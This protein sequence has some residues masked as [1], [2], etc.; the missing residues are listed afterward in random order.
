[1]TLQDALAILAYLDAGPEA[2]RASQ[3]PGYYEARRVVFD[4]AMRALNRF[5]G[6]SCPV[7][8]ETK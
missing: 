8:E 1:M 4:E 3:T 2:V 6:Y 5:N 7:D